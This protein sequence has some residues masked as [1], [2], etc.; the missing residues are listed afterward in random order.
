MPMPDKSPRIL[1]VEDDQMFGEILTKRFMS[2]GAVIIHV[3]NGKDALDTLERE[4][5]FDVILLDISLPDM[6]GFEVLKRLRAVEA[7]KDI[8]VVVVSNFV[9]DKDIDWGRNM[10]VAQFIQKSNVMPGDIVNAALDALPK[11]GAAVQA[12]E[13]PIANS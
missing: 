7:F 9:K 4:K 12:Q 10:G 5:I 2:G 6:D 11:D 1:L 13:Q 3:G 8:P